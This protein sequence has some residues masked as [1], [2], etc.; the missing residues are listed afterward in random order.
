MM[1][2]LVGYCCPFN[3]AVPPTFIR[4]TWP[5]TFHNSL[6]PYLSNMETTYQKWSRA[7]SVA[8]IKHR[9][10]LLKFRGQLKYLAKDGNTTCRHQGC[11]EED[12]LDHAL[13]CP[14]VTT[15]RPVNKSPREL[16]RFI[17]GLNRE[18]MEKFRF[19]LI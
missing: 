14:W 2:S 12:T 9:V 19:P 15:Y 11:F 7:E 17:V 4:V 1:E 10:G 3:P 16:A 8:I 6:V 5:L 18:R 13:K